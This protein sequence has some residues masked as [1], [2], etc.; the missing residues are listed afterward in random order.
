LPKKTFVVDAISLDAYMYRLAPFLQSRNIQKIVWDGRLGYSELWHRYEIRL[1]NVLDL[2]LVYLHERYDGTLRSF[3]PLSGKISAIR[4][5]KLLSPVFLEGE[6]K[7][8]I[9]FFLR[10]IELGA[11]LDGQSWDQRPLTTVNLEHASSQMSHLRLLA[12]V[13]T[14]QA[15]KHPNILRESKRY[16]ELYHSHRRQSGNPYEIHK[17]LPQGIFERTES[18]NALKSLGTRRC[19]GCQRDLYQE[20][21]QIDFRRWQRNPEKQYCFTCD[22]VNA[23]KYR[24]DRFWDVLELAKSR[25]ASPILVAET[26]C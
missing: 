15:A 18:E 26:K 2:Q 10:L 12:T 21:F 16:I 1:E 20:S 4:E 7:R 5:K 13:L 14:H 22:K 8:I 9:S 24:R 23:R 25:T 11:Q 6:L 17:Y 19:R 3:I